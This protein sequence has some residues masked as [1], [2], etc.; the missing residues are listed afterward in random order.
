MD[1]KIDEATRWLDRV[2]T[3]VR[4]NGKPRADLKESL[5]TQNQNTRG[6][7]GPQVDGEKK[8]N[9]CWVRGTRER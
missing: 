2:S 4:Q 5:N 1:A 3:F 7:Y 9:V 8:K 6:I